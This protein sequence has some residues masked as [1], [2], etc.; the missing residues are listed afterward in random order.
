M[1]NDECR[2]MNAELIDMHRSRFILKSFAIRNPQSAI[3]NPQS[4]KESP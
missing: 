1:M 2:M 3:T 4:L